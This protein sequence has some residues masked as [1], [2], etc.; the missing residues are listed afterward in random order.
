M[1]QRSVSV[2]VRGLEIADA[3]NK[4]ARHMGIES[5]KASYG[6]LWRFRNRQGIGNKVERVESGSVDISAVEPFRL[7]FNRIMKKENL[8]LGKLY[9]TQ[10]KL[11]L[12]CC[13]K[14]KYLLTLIPYVFPHTLMLRY[15]RGSSCGTFVVNIVV[16]YRSFTSWKIQPP[17]RLP[18]KRP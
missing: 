17:V 7:K 5:F 6:L 8:H 10:G 12:T 14:F 2:N 3:A 4:L 18:D 11:N 1:Q 13:N 9:T 15:V 16:T